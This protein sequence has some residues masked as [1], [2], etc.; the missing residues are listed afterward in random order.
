MFTE[1]LSAFFD[2]HADVMTHTPPGY[3]H[4]GAESVTFSGIFDAN[5]LELD[6]GGMVQV[7]G[8]RSV[9]VCDLADVPGLNEGSK[10]Q[11][12]DDLYRVNGYDLDE[13]GTIASA[14]LTLEQ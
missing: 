3:P 8:V 11:H 9:V 7:R 4:P 6:A 10:I 13:T 2:E 5:A 14:I 1:N 12:G